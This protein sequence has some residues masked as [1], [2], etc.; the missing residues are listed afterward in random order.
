MGKD[1]DAY[2]LVKLSSSHHYSWRFPS[3]CDP[4]PWMRVRIHWKCFPFHGYMTLVEIL[5]PFRRDFMT[6]E[7]WMLAIALYDSNTNNTLTWEEISFEN[8]ILSR[9]KSVYRVTSDAFTLPPRRPHL[10]E[11]TQNQKMRLSTYSWH[12][13]GLVEFSHLLFL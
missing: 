5:R 8:L 1:A 2:K 12:V 11:R 4:D 6:F 7:S 13:L 3:L 10:L 9:K